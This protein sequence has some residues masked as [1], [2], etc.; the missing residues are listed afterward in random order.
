MAEQF[1]LMRASKTYENTR[2]ERSI[3]IAIR[4]FPAPPEYA[5]D[6]LRIE[7]AAD[8]RVDGR[9]EASG[10]LAARILAPVKNHP[11]GC[12]GAG[13][14]IGSFRRRLCASQRVPQSWFSPGRIGSSKSGAEASSIRGDARAR[15]VVIG[16]IFLRIAPRGSTPDRAAATG[17]A[18]VGSMRP[19]A[20]IPKLTR[21][22]HRTEQNH[23]AIASNNGVG[24]AG[25]LMKRSHREPA[26]GRGSDRPGSSRSALSRIARACYE[27][28]RARTLAGARKP[29]ALERWVRCQ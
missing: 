17:L 7:G 16:T 4:A 8:W 22:S 9:V 3:P 29:R 1:S 28:T 12:G 27:G 15:H 13:S 6:G 10:R 19:S 23:P 25:I 5:R 18:K 24:D 2:V 11:A 14:A 21:R 20:A 26:A